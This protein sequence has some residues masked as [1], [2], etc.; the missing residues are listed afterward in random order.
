MRMQSSIKTIFSYPILWNAPQKHV[1]RLWIS[2]KIL[3][4]SVICTFFLLSSLEG[5]A[6]TQDPSTLFQLGNTSY[7]QKNY[8]KAIE[9]YSQIEQS[10]LQSV[11]LY[12]NLGN[13]YFRQGQYAK[14]ILYYERALRL[15]PKNKDILH[16]L[17]V[18]RAR[19]VDQFEI[20]PDFFLYRW[21]QNFAFLLPYTLWTIGILIFWGLF[22][23]FTSQYLVSKTYSKKKLYFKIATFCLFFGLLSFGSAWIYH[24]FQEK[25]QAIIMRVNASVKTAPEADSKTKFIIHEGCKI[26]LE[27]QINSYYKIRI[28]DGNTGWLA[29]DNFEKI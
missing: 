18:T 8:T 24:S 28:S 14:S 9:K 6:E 20:L 23:W 11:A 26:D 12:R 1:D 16:N 2:S 21:A 22:L 3:I 29:E 4:F 19:L 10:N 15:S 25:P 7:N 17:D 13:A 5:K 27:D